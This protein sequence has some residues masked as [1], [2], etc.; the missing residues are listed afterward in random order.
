MAVA[1]E[2]DMRRHLT[3]WEKE[4]KKL[5]KVWAPHPACTSLPQAHALRITE[6]EPQRRLSTVSLSLRP[7]TVQC[8]CAY[9]GLTQVCA[10]R[11]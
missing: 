8:F 7:A 4:N 2:L 3:I 6:P 11:A 9:S 1:K 10:G 5:A